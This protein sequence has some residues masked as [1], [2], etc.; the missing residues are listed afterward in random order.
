MVSQDHQVIALVAFAIYSIGS[1]IGYL[2]HFRLAPFN[3]FIGWWSLVLSYFGVLIY[4][5]TYPLP[6]MNLGIADVC[7][8]I[9]FSLVSIVLI[10]RVLSIILECIYD[11]EKYNID[12]C[13]LDA[14][15]YAKEQLVWHKR[16][17]K[18][19]NQ[20]EK[21]KKWQEIYRAER[22]K[23]DAIKM[24]QEANEKKEDDELLERFKQ[25]YYT[26]NKLTES[27]IP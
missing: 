20:A 6:T 9:G 16:E 21:E 23:R 2:F 14:E 4:L 10:S 3:R 7:L 18:R 17:Q 13:R 26:L 22:E 25:Q 5:K 19:I 27:I 1:F 24:Q 11:V 15:V 8:F 12:G